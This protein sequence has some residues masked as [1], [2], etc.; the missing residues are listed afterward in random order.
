MIK[1]IS[2]FILVILLSCTQHIAIDLGVRFCGDISD[3]DNSS[4]DSAKIEVLDIKGTGHKSIGDFIGRVYYSDTNGS[5]CLNLPGGVEWDEKIFSKN[6][7]YTKYISSATIKVSKEP[8]R[9]TVVT[10]Q[11][12]NYEESRLD[13]KIVLQ[14]Q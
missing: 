6:K 14:K 12:T 1:T 5:F 10:I 7:E 9:D 11:N 8:Y 13:I 2:P 3:K 4:I